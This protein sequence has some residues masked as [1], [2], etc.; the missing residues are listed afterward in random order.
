MI[1]MTA[2]LKIPADGLT[3]ED[4]D[5]FVRTVSGLAEVSDDDVAVTAYGVEGMTYAMLSATWNI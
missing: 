2:E 1:N 5:S 3:L 4:L